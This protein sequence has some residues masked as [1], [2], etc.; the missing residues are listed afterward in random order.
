MFD[1][2]PNPTVSESIEKWP[3]T[4]RRPLMRMTW[5]SLSLIHWR[6]DPAIITPHLPA[7]LTLDTFDGTG[8]LGLVP[9]TMTDVSPRYVP[10]LPIRGLTDFHECNVRTYVTPTDG[11]PRGVWFFSLDAASRMAVSMARRFFH[12][13]YFNARISLV[14]RDGTITYGVDRLD[15]SPGNSPG[16]SSGHPLGTLRCAWTVDR[17]SQIDAPPGSLEHF[18]TERYVLF[19]ANRAGRVFLGRV[20]HVPWTL[21]PAVLESLDESLIAAD[22]LPPPDHAP[23]H[24]MAADP[25]AVTGWRLE[26]LR[27]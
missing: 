9:F 26:A 4:H 19:S 6:V 12:L 21:R 11:G 10:R 3:P 14:E 5:R 1:C 18:L 7:G 13:P 17:S 27:G 15:P 16:H 25:L 2:T 22:G 8:W 20:D 23:D 24:I